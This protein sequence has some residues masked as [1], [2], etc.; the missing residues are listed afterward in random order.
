MVAPGWVF[1]CITL[2]LAISVQSATFQIQDVAD[3]SIS[4]ATPGFSA[5]DDIVVLRASCVSITAITVGQ[6]TVQQVAASSGGCSKPGV[7]LV[8]VT[9]KG[10]LTVQ[11]S[12]FTRASS[13]IWIENSTLHGPVVLDQNRFSSGAAL[14]VIDTS[15]PWSPARWNFDVRFAISNCYFV[16][17]TVNIT[18]VVLQATVFLLGACAFAFSSTNVSQ[19]ALHFRRFA[20][21]TNWGA[22]FAKQVY[23][24]Q[25][26]YVSDSS[27]HI[28][29]TALTAYEP[30]PSFIADGLWSGT[31]VTLSNVT[32]TGGA[33]FRGRSFRA[34]GTSFQSYVTI[35]DLHPLPGNPND[36]LVFQNVFVQDR[37][38]ITDGHLTQ[39]QFHLENISTARIAVPERDMGRIEIFNVTFESTRV[40]FVAVSCLSASWQ[41]GNCG[42]RFTGS[43]SIAGSSHTYDNVVVQLSGVANPSEANVHYDAASTV[44]DGTVTVTDCV[45]SG[46]G[47]PH[48]LQMVGNFRDSVVTLRNVTQKGPCSIS[49][50]SI[51]YVDGTIGGGCVLFGL[52]PRATEGLDLRRLYVGGRILIQHGAFL[53]SRLR[54]ESITTGRATVE[55]DQGRIEIY[56]VTFAQS[57]LTFCNVSCLSA[58]WNLRNRGIQFALSPSNAGTTHEYVNVYVHLSG[59]GSN[60]SEVNVYYDPMSAISDGAVQITDSVFEAES[61]A[62]GIVAASSWPNSSVTLRNVT[63]TGPSVL[64]GSEFIY[65]VGY[66]GSSLTLN[67]VN[68]SREDGGVI[69]ENL[70]IGDRLLYSQGRI[71]N[72]RLVLANITTGRA[73]PPARGLGRIEINGV[74]FRR[75][76]VL[77][78][79]VDCLSQRWHPAT[80]G[81]LFTASPSTNSDHVFDSVHVHI[82]GGTIPDEV[83]VKYTDDSAVTDGSFRATNCSFQSDNWACGLMALGWWRNTT[84]AL[85]NVSQSGCTQLSG[86]TITYSVGA[87]GGTLVAA[88]F[89][90]RAD[91]AAGFLL[92]NA[93][94]AGL[95]SFS[96]GVLDRTT[97]IVRRVT[98]ADASPIVFLPRIELRNLT[99]RHSQ[100]TFSHV[101]SDATFNSR[102][103]K[104]VGFVSCAMSDTAVLFSNFNATMRNGDDDYPGIALDAATPLWNGS[105]TVVD[106]VLTSPQNRPAGIIMQGPVDGS[107]VRVQNLRSSG[108]ISL[109]VSHT[110][111]VQDVV[112][113]GYVSVD[114]TAADGTPVRASQWSIRDVIVPTRGMFLYVGHGRFEG[115]R[116]YTSPA[117]ARVMVS[118][119]SLGDGLAVSNAAVVQIDDL[120]VAETAVLVSDVSASVNPSS[121]NGVF[122][123]D[124]CQFN[125]SVLYL[126]R[127]TLQTPGDQHIVK[128]GPTSSLVNTTMD[129]ANSSFISP[130]NAMSFAMWTTASAGTHICVTNSSFGGAMQLV[131]NTVSVI[132]SNIDGW[133]SIATLSCDDSA[134]LEPR[135]GIDVVS[136]TFKGPVLFSGSRFVRCGV[137]IMSVAVLGA[138]PSASHGML[139]FQ[140]LL[141]ESSVLVV[142]NT[143]IVGSLRN[144]QASAIHFSSCRSVDSTHTFRN[145]TLDGGAAMADTASLVAYDAGSSHTNGSLLMDSVTMADSTGIGIGYSFRNEFANFTNTSVVLQRVRMSK[146][147]VVHASSAA[148]LDVQGNFLSVRSVA[149]VTPFSEA[150]VMERSSFTA[151]VQIAGFAAVGSRSSQNASILIRDVYLGSPFVPW[152]SY[153]CR[154]QLVDLSL[155]N[156]SIALV[157]VT[158]RLQSRTTRNCAVLLTNVALFNSTLR[159]QGLNATLDGAGVGGSEGAVLLVNPTLINSTIVV[160]SANIAVGQQGGFAFRALEVVPA[161]LRG[162][163]VCVFNSRFGQAADFLADSVFVAV[164]SDFQQ[165]MSLNADGGVFSS[166]VAGMTVVFAMANCTVAGLGSLVLGGITLPTGSTAS[167]ANV[168]VEQASVAGSSQARLAINRIDVAP[169]AVL[170]LRDVTVTADHRHSQDAAVD[171][172]VSAPRLATTAGIAPEAAA[173]WFQNVSFTM[174]GSPA[175]DASL[176]RFAGASAPAVAS[177]LVMSASTLRSS[178]VYSPSLSAT[179]LKDTTLCFRDS[180]FDTPVQLPADVGLVEVTGTSNFKGGLVVGGVASDVDAL[181]VSSCGP[182]SAMLATAQ[183]GD[184]ELLAMVQREELQRASWA[185]VGRFEQN[186]P[187]LTDQSDSPSP[188]PR[189]IVYTV[190]TVIQRP[191]QSCIVL[192]E[193]GATTATP[194][195]SISDSL[196]FTTT[197]SYSSVD[198]RSHTLSPRVPK[199]KPRSRSPARAERESP[200]R[201]HNHQQT[202]SLESPA[203]SEYYT[204]SFNRTA[205]IASVPSSSEDD[206]AL[207]ADVRRK[208]APPLAVAAVSA[209][210]SSAMAALTVNGIGP[211]TV[212]RASRIASIGKL[213]ECVTAHVDHD[214]LEDLDTAPSYVEMP[215]QFR[216]KVGTATQDLDGINAANGGVLCSCLLAALGAA[217]SL[218]LYLKSEPL[219][220]HPRAR[221]IIAVNGVLLPAFFAPNVWAV[222]AKIVSAAT[223]GTDGLVAFHVSALVVVAVAVVPAVWAAIV[224]PKRCEPRDE[225]RDTEQREPSST[226]RTAFHGTLNN[227]DPAA[228]FVEYFS[229]TVD[230][231]RR[232][233]GN[234]W[235]RLHVSVETASAMLLG[236]LAAVHAQG[237]TAC[238][239]KAI[240][241][242]LLCTLYLTYLIVVRPY[243]STLE[244]FFVSATG[245]VQLAATVA[246]LVEFAAP[247]AT[248]AR[249]MAAAEGLLLVQT[250][251]LILQPLAVLAWL[252]IRKFRRRRLRRCNASN[253]APDST[254]SCAMQPLL[255]LPAMSD[256]CAVAI[257]LASSTALS[258]DLGNL[259]AGLSESIRVNPLQ[260]SHA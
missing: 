138:S 201:T 124:R 89:D 227:T 86:R 225:R 188:E 92:E 38:V 116:S 260:A 91:D 13:G 157:N 158:S 183:R 199:G 23:F 255:V 166:P 44:T 100:L 211:G 76:T 206:N 113:F 104:N 2:L 214:R 50:R 87:V 106:S 217:V 182:T 56:N 252:V 230:G 118:N 24:D 135:L 62:S 223:W 19:S 219:R 11:A 164:A 97:F 36:G 67:D 229:V 45:F 181:R 71:T 3:V 30:S 146:A 160:T 187:Y 21:S 256:T 154:L 140:Q 221:A 73:A 236:L 162:S 6:L 168:T 247:P 22:A 120:W 161:S 144:G 222:S 193:I 103:T 155:V 220:T 107:S 258:E 85:R 16:G 200:T 9:V 112:V 17:A 212:S 7:T 12:N 246:V 139:E 176:L 149:G 218:M 5:G 142:Y 74:V 29:D 148:F 167:I 109:R 82:N 190:E 39:S 216:L 48:G 244:T 179:T 96:D 46:D 43:P 245:I 192:E 185:P 165:P 41:L 145:L 224:A 207:A 110:L 119:I 59:G 259:E 35:R 136:S 180:Q 215:V 251:L 63:Q 25:A 191:V 114:G 61:G 122:F 4:A 18:R 197:P 175:G 88:H 205:S 26:T 78:R 209:V 102:G 55:V 117:E 248:A 53:N 170:V 54:L 68:S 232:F 128:I 173:Y 52:T 15:L 134:T 202:R 153:Q 83:N 133:S 90:A 80:A 172:S 235:I 111:H 243:R 98:F 141:L 184:A 108:R 32:L 257:S 31:E 14:A 51:T 94:V 115:V 213:A 159:L 178:L 58:N 84:V 226:S 253:E 174:N 130:P 228:P 249:A 37:L 10:T 203:P 127:L 137:R 40:T 250:L 34:S 151:I 169:G 75:S 152:A 195:E 49:G 105:F 42:I 129:I 241:A 233:P 150:L 194:S 57:A 72:S 210:A 208:L 66:M 77:F 131:A 1:T 204:R 132:G 163:S 60:P 143:I 121:N 64:S 186:R 237:F 20:V 27:L 99:L 33:V 65:R 177:R 79:N 81:I 231:A 254:D 171:I 234:V 189:A 28:E 198:T 239:A 126:H 101:Q 147:S 70:Y 95:V 196:T 156:T 240:A 238:V 125:N 242:V 123:I 93:T 8:T 69:L 47:T